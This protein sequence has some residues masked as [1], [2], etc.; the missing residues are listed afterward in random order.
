VRESVCQ[1]KYWCN[2]SEICN[3]KYML[4]R[5]ALDIDSLKNQEPGSSI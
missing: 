3:T 5:K 2:E 4:P 1:S